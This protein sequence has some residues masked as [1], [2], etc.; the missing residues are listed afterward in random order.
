MKQLLALSIMSLFLN[1][2][3]AEE[4]HNKHHS[5]AEEEKRHSVKSLSLNSGKK[6]DVDQTMRLNMEAIN[7]QFNK[8]KTL[9]NNKKV[10][11]SDYSELS[12]TISDSAQNIATN[13]KMEQ[14]KD[15]TFHTVLG[16]LMTVSE[17]LKDSTK[18]KHATEKLNHALTI[19]TEYFNH[20]F[21]K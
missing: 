21:S 1:S 13:C 18:V 4:N 14:K 20:S 8:L 6:W 11:A 9:V 5:K 19:Y 17:D 16:D 3:Y 15:E 12:K 2:S 7:N 10:T